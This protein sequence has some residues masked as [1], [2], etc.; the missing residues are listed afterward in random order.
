MSRLRHSTI[1]PGSTS[2]ELEI[3]AAW[4]YYVEGLTQADVA[5]ALRVSRA[6]VVRL[7]A[8]ARAT[9]IV[10]IRVDAASVERIAL[11][12]RLIARFGLA[13]AIVVDAPRDPTLVARAVGAAA[14]AWLR[15][16]VRDGVVV[17]VGWGETLEAAARGLDPRPL[18]RASVISLLGGTTR[19]HGVNP[20]AVA[21]RMADAWG[22]EC[23]QL[24]APL[25]VS[26]AAM[27]TALWSEPALRDLR[28]RAMR[29][30]VAL[31]SVGDVSE[32]STLFREGLLDSAELARLS[33]AGA[34]GDVLG[35][36]LDV[37]GRLAGDPLDAR[38]IAV[39]LAALTRVRRIAIASGGAR[40][41]R[42]L[43]AALKALPV[44]ALV[45]DT[46]AAHGLLGDR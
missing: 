40:K 23:Y 14:A 10:R 32:Q 46:T 31:L 13:T 36:F 35:H 18:Q 9:G 2:P 3:R 29:A 6:K 17:G 45:T 38:V 24:V 12:R 43:A 15:D 41:V 11:E 20:F 25:K 42:A 21:R 22:A 39:D 5:A 28:R 26:D 27:A 19:S 33:A 44:A 34:V 16:T 37:N 1:P 7:L 4:H 8:A 30:D